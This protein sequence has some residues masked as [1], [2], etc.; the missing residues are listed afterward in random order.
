MLLTAGAARASDAL[1][2]MLARSTTVGD[3]VAITELA[4]NSLKPG[5]TAGLASVGDQENALG[6]GVGSDGTV[7]VWKRQKNKDE[8]VTTATAPKST[9]VWLRLS[10]RN[11]HLFRFAFSGDG[12]NWT[13]VGPELNG[14][15]MPPWDRGLRVALTV[16]GTAGAAARFNSLRIAPSVK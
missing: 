6:I 8:V 5:V 16:G 10:A 7:N 12:R 1:G 13:D 4:A 2:G 3:Y 9:S 15:Y 11:G 14:D